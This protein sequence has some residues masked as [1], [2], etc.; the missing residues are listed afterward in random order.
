MF[1]YELAS[2]GVCVQHPRMRPH[3]VLSRRPRPRILYETSPHRSARVSPLTIP[4]GDRLRAARFVHA[5]N[6]EEE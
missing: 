5:R 6:I 1:V 4:N 2:I 3:H